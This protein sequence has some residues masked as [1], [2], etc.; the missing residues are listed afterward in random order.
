M[1]RRALQPPDNHGF[2]LFGAR[3]TGKSTLIGE[4]FDIQKA[5]WINLLDLDQGEQFM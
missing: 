2:F 1:L 5:L 3:D 4:Q